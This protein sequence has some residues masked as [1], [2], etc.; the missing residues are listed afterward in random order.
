MEYLLH[1]LILFSIYGI[2]GVSLNLVVGYT[3][4]LSVAHAAFYGIG[5]YAT[6]VLL[7]SL[8]VNFFLASLAGVLL[9]MM[10]GFLMGIV[11]SKFKGD[12]Y[13]L[14]TLGFCGV[15]FSIFLN[16]DAVTN[17]S[18]GISGIVRPSLFGF[19]FSSNFSFFV[20]ALVF[21]GIVYGISYGITTS[22][23]GRVLRAVREDEQAVQV[24]GYRTSYFK[25]I[26]FIIS[27]GMAALAGSLYA[28]YITFID[29][30]SFTIIESVFILVI[31][32]VGGLSDS[33]GALLG[34]LILVLLLETLRFVGFP[35]AVAAQMRQVFYGLVLVG[36]MLWRPRGILG[37]YVL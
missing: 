11:F 20:L 15:V 4:L 6:A 12:Y 30:L 19:S 33:K 28:S 34:A 3:G 16:W 27:A 1:L 21:L 35:V 8:N 23:F 18:L 5:A 14:A 22:S 29:P 25:L 17:G 13:A 10:V 24:F 7:T 2:L 36:L 32:I 31:I 9:A 37:R 26:I